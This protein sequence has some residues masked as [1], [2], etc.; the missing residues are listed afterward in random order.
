MTARRIL[1]CVALLLSG[2]TSGVFFGTRAAIGPSTK[3]FR[4]TTYIEV[5]QATVRNLRP[6]MGTLLP[7]SVAANLALA[8]LAA[9]ESDRPRAFALIATGLLGQAASL[10]V[11]ARY[12]LPINSRVLTWSPAD[13]PPG[14]QAARD[15][16]DRFHTIRTATSVVGFGCLTVAVIRRSAVGLLAT[17]R[18]AR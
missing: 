9:R 7:A 5:Q 1:A 15:R 14:W 12:E 16:W 10:A 2:L 18:A 8:V 4:G 6:V 11:T 3:S 17:P 13:P